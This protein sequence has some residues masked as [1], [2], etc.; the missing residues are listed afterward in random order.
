MTGTV[1]AIAGG[2]VTLSGPVILGVGVAG[3]EGARGV[4]AAGGRGGDVGGVWATRQK[5]AAKSER[6]RKNLI[7]I[8]YQ[9]REKG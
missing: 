6:I 2:K 3:V 1:G 9:A 7:T 8:G 5:P 4:A